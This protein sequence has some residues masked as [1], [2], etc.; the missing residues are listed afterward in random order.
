[1]G[2]SFV[3]LRSWEVFLS[4]LFAL[5]VELALVVHH[6]MAHIGCMKFVEILKKQVWHPS[7]ASVAND[8]TGTCDRC[9]RWNHSPIVSPLVTK[10]Q[11]SF[12]FELVAVDVVAFP[13][14]YGNIGYLV[15]LDHHFEVACSSAN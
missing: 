4:P 15:V 10:I 1:M 13:H 11:T 6:R 8:V 9:Q 5:L 2:F 7:L 14:S 3:S 12:P